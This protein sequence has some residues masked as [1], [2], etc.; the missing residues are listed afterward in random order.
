MDRLRL[1]QADLFRG[2]PQ[3]EVFSLIVSNPPYVPNVELK[4]LQRE[5]QCEPQAALAGGADGLD[6]IRRL[7]AEAPPHL[8]AGGYLM[9]EFGINQDKAITELLEGTVW[10]LI[11]VRRDLQQIPRIIILRKK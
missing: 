7:M 11:E 8:R 5:V 6:V 3:P 10:E 9:F 1:V 2:V 4:S